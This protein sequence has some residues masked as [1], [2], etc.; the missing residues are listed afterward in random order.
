[1]TKKIRPANS[2]RRL[3]E[4]RKNAVALAKAR[5]AL[6]EH[7]GDLEDLRIAEAR[8]ADIDA[9]R[10]VPLPWDEVREGL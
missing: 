4:A 8:L 3:P 5:R 10:V 9:G 2:A 7:I 6:E 1:M